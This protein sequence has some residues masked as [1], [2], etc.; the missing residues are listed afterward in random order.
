MEHSICAHAARC[1]K[2]SELNEIECVYEERD[3]NNNK[4][5][6]NFHLKCRFQLTLKRL[7]GWMQIK[8]LLAFIEILKKK[9]LYN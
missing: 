8:I 3:R 1:F 7:C 2:S 6:Y 9:K 4:I 5:K